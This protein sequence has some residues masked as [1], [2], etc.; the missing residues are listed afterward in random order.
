MLFCWQNGN[1]PL[2]MACLS[3][4]VV[5]A[6]I[7][8]AKGADLNALNTVSKIIESTLV[9]GLLSIFVNF[10]FNEKKKIF[11]LNCMIFKHVVIVVGCQHSWLMFVH[12]VWV[13]FQR[14]QSPIHIAAEQGYSE[15][16]KLLLSAGA[17][18]EQ[19]EQV[20]NINLAYYNLMNGE[21]HIITRR[22]STK[23]L[24]TR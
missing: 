5:I 20:D 21:A 3:N 23:S 19:R 17:N 12:H 15:I 8:I 11:S 7:L 9:R 14:L 24:C 2:H 6:E 13:C 22:M 18:I 10:V 4:N 1:T 16:C